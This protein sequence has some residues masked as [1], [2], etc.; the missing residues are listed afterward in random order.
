MHHRASAARQLARRAGVIAVWLV[1]CR[2]I[3]TCCLPR[4]L[5]SRTPAKQRT[6]KISVAVDA[7]CRHAFEHGLDSE[8]LRLIIQIVSKKTELDQTSV[9]NLVK[10]LFPAQRVRAD[11]V[12]T[13][14]GG[15]GQGKIKPSTATQIGLVKWLITVH[16]VLE[17]PKILSRLYGVLF[18]ML[19]MISLR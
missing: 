12:I 15:L 17:D 6:A 16:E 11:V 13:V 2:V 14:V 5:A 3:R 9:T 1:L 7:I 4:I 18:G 19:D 8:S 10:N